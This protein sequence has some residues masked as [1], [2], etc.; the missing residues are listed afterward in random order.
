MDQ[1]KRFGMVGDAKNK[2]V[3]KLAGTGDIDQAG[4]RKKKG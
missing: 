3:H 4:R 2:F 1:D